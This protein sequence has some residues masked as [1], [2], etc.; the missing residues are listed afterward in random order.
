[1][2]KK[3]HHEEH[4]EHVNHEAWVIPYA[5]LLTLLM[6]LFLVLWASSQS[7]LSKLKAVSAG[8]ADQLG[9]SGQGAGQ[10]GQGVLA[11]SAQ[12]D[13]TT[14]QPLT[15]EHEAM[16][17]AALRA[18]QA[19]KEAAQADQSQLKGVQSAITSSAAAAGTSQ[20]LAFQMQKRGLV[21]SIVTEGVL[22]DAGSADLRPEGKAILDQ[23][24]GELTKVP[25]ELAIE[26]HTD[27]Q[28][29]S[30]SQYPSNWELSTARAT[31]VLRYLVSAHS[32][33]PSRLTAAGYG[34]ERPLAP[35]TPAGRVANRRVDIAILDLG[36]NPTAP[37]NQTTT[38]LN[39]LG[40]GK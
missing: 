19:A 29:I 6:A 26:G 34:D 1:V 2:R 7:D 18:Q 22:F 11:G 30:N 9:V 39:E 33:D 23:I 38:T 32:L 10:G 28:P 21:V 31:N 12:P 5:D 24:A 36:N 17:M 13:V 27:D 40:A 37:A 3:Q 4:E 8:F 15:P 14:T 35:N 20:D 25:N 16:A